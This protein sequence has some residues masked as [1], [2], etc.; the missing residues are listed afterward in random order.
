[1]GET[2]IYRSTGQYLGF[3][4]NGRLF[5]RDGAFLGS[6]SGNFVWDAKGQYRGTI[7][8][9]NE[10]NYIVKNMFA[11]PPYNQPKVEGG[12]L[13]LNELPNPHANINPIVLPVGYIDGF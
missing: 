13:Q 7:T 2:I 4:R 10:S 12:N 8:V 11:I 5:S 9:F 6:T 3:I 1:M